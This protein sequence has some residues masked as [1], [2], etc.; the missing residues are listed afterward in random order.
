MQLGLELGQPVLNLL[1]L[2]LLLLQRLV[3]QGILSLGFC[4][5][6]LLWSHNLCDPVVSLHGSDPG[7]QT[8][9]GLGCLLDSLGLEVLPVKVW[10]DFADDGWLDVVLVILLEVLEESSISK[11]TLRWRPVV[12]DLLHWVVRIIHTLGLDLEH[13]A[14]RLHHRFDGLRWVLHGLDQCDVILGQGVESGDGCLKEWNGFGELGLALIFDGLGRL[15]L[16]VCHGF[17][18]LHHGE[19]GLGLLSFLVHHNKGLLHLLT[20]LHQHR[21]QSNELLFHHADTLLCR[22]KLLQ[23]NLIP[24]S[25]RGH[26]QALGLQ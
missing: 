16:D 18:L 23:P 19:L 26:L 8:I 22:Q 20:G 11:N 9:G 2:S 14:N 6:L 1:E 12:I 13:D 25:H 17:F 21:L 4:E 7:A 5:L 10:P 24:V 3:K 15:G